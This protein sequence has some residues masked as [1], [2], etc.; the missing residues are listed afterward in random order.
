[1]SPE[2]VGPSDVESVLE[3]CVRAAV[4]RHV[5]YRGDHLELTLLGWQGGIT[6]SPP[7]PPRRGWTHTL[8][9]GLLSGVW[10][11]PDLTQRAARTW[12]ESNEPDLPSRTK[13]GVS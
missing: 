7:P 2:E 12:R 13:C 9:L 1:M 6:P 11:Y 3:C 8:G 5:D 4:S 10:R